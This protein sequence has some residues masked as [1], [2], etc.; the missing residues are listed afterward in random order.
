[1]SP[2]NPSFIIGDKITKD[3]AKYCQSPGNHI[4]LGEPVYD[5][6]DFFYIVSFAGA[7]RLSLLQGHLGH[8]SLFIIVIF[9]IRNA[10]FCVF[11]LLQFVISCF[12]QVRTARSSG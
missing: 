12:V 5:I 3:R 7:F 11:P 2:I 1:M 4:T 9:V 6:Q 10:F 8:G